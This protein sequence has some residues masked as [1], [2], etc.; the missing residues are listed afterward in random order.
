[1]M[2]I[3]MRSPTEQ[4]TLFPGCWQCNAPLVWLR[5]EAGIPSGRHHRLWRCTDCEAVTR[6]GWRPPCW[7]NATQ[8][9]WMALSAELEDAIEDAY[10]ETD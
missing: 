4:Q 9:V 10:T 3:R 2:D 5:A 6:T 1:M 8:R 7:I